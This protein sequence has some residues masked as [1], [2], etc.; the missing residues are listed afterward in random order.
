MF[1]SLIHRLRL[2]GQLKLAGI[3]GGGSI[4]VQG[5]SFVSSVIIIRTLS[6]EN[7][8]LYA[9]TYAGLG[10][11]QAISDG[12]ISQA[13]ITLGG[14]IHKDPSAL[15]NMMATAHR[16][17]VENVCVASLLVIPLWLWSAYK[18]SSGVISLGMLA[19][20]IVVTSAFQVSGNTY[21]SLLFLRDDISYVQI[22]ES[23]A[24]ILRLVAIA[25]TIPFFPDPVWAV[26]SGVVID[27]IRTL[28]LKRRCHL[29][30]PAGGVFEKN[31]AKDIRSFT[32]KL[33]P[34]TIYRAFS[35]QI[36]LFILSVVGTSTSVAGAG[37]LGR[38]Q[39]V[40]AVVPSFVASLMAPRIAREQNSRAVVGL[41]WKFTA[42]SVLMPMAI[43]L[44]L[45]LF[46]GMLSL[47]F[48]SDYQGIEMETRT[49][50]LSCAIGVAA[51]GVASCSN[52]RKWLISPLLVIPIHMSA[53]LAALLIFGS[54]N[55][56]DYARTQ[57]VV[58]AAMLIINLAWMAKNNARS[59][60]N[61][62][63]VSL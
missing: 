48:G 52:A 26:G 38:I 21:K 13:V 55:V 1:K 18:H 20:L 27:S 19:A 29:Y 22:S 33:L 30:C 46:P 25:A 8:A 62:A 58:S 60:S 51:A 42:I 36:L 47:A 23:V 40:F 61:F 5:V 39:Q 12:A 44:P 59:R 6:T 11:S 53:M 54:S 10:I 24:A 32:F 41:T 3:V 57:L 4:A 9:L 49:F 15:S 35:S 14:R 56:M 45:L 16:L 7:F 43:S 31:V 63:T 2:G 28:Y 50:T 37:V 17:M 34:T